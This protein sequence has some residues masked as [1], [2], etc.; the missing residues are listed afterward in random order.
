[1]AVNHRKLE[2]S[3]NALAKELSRAENTSAQYRE[4]ALYIAAAKDALY[5][6]QNAPQP[7]FTRE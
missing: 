4:A 3:I 5:T 1:M 7:E 6:L 2:H